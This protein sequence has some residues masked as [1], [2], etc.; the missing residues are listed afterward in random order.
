MIGTNINSS[1]NI[2]LLLGSKERSIENLR[3]II[4]RNFLKARALSLLNFFLPRNQQEN[5][6]PE[7]ACFSMNFFDAVRLEASPLL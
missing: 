5:G 7:A 1:R 6:M 2:A 4:H 3:K